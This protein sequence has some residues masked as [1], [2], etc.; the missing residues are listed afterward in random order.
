MQAL[1]LGLQ[2]QQAKMTAAKED[3]NTLRS[4]TSEEMKDKRTITAEL[5]KDYVAS[6]RPQSAAGKQALDEGL[7]HGTAP[8]Q[9]RVADISN[10]N[11]EK[12]MAQVNSLISGMTVAQANLALAQGKF[13]QAQKQA[14][15][16]TPTEMKLKSGSEDLLANLDQAKTDLKQAFALNPNTFDNSLPDMAQRKVL[17]AAGSKDQKLLNTRILD[18]LLSTGAIAQLREK[19]GSQF[20]QAEGKLWMDLQGIGAKSKEER[21][22]VMANMY[23]ALDAKVAK[24]QKRL[25]EINR[26][27]YREPTPEGIE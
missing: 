3:L 19:F 8:Y 13:E 9:K 10:M 1:Q 11:V 4:L 2:G 26:R 24:E 6:G 27:A 14:A 22:Q 12:Q 23:K 15:K 16:L 20:T 17:E 5:I 21:A 7:V 25:N 18:N